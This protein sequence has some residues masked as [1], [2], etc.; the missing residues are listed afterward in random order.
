MVETNNHLR[1]Q[2]SENCS[3]CEDEM[4]LFHEKNYDEEKLIKLIH[5]K[6]AKVSVIVDKKD[7]EEELI[8]W[9]EE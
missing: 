6:L 3:S 1:G 8:E 7:N 9:Q 4:Y 5:E 2:C